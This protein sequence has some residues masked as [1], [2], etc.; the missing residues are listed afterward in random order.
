MTISSSR[1]ADD[2][3]LFTVGRSVSLFFGSKVNLNVPSVNL[4]IW[5]TWKLQELKVHNHQRKALWLSYKTKHLLL[6]GLRF[7]HLFL[8]HPQ[9]AVFTA[10]TKLRFAVLGTFGLFFCFFCMFS[11]SLWHVLFHNQS[12]VKYLDTYMWKA[13]FR[14]FIRDPHVTIQHHKCLNCQI[15]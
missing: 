2:S 15:N 11:D 3:R 13:Q 1:L 10:F 5:A 7:M 4:W 8:L 14:W 9:R 6:D 12:C